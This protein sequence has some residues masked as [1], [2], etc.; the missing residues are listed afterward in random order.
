MIKEF[1]YKHYIVHG[2]YV[3]Y[4]VAWPRKVWET[5]APPTF[6]QDGAWD[7]FEVNEKIIGG[8]GE[9]VANLQRSRGR[10]EENFIFAP[11]FSNPGHAPA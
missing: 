6:S 2:E 11:H 5:N 1:L 3:I 10:G 7:F 4:S 8:R 9:I